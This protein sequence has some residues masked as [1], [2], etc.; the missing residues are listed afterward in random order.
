[1]SCIPEGVYQLDKKGTASNYEVA[2]VKG[3]TYIMIHVANFEGCGC[4]GI[5]ED[6]GVVNNDWAIMRSSESFDKFMLEMATHEAW[7]LSIQERTTTGHST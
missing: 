6:L 1:M 3:R 7:N 5:G 4:I 2:N